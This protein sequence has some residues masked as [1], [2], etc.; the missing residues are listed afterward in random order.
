M[1]TST[2]LVK[3]EQTTPTEA[4][5]EEVDILEEKKRLEAVVTEFEL[6]L[7]QMIFDLSN[8]HPDLVTKVNQQTPP[9]IKQYLTDAE[10]KE[11]WRIIAGR[12]HPDK[13]KNKDEVLHSIFLRAKKHKEEGNLAELYFCYIELLE[14]TDKNSLVLRLLKNSDVIRESLQ[15]LKTRYEQMKVG[16]FGKLY[17]LY[18]INRIGASMQYR[19]YL[20]MKA[21]NQI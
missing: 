21:K 2:E 6:K 11:I 19:N 8:D 16:F 20:I 9:P 12:C 3:V 1:T 4:T 17:E 13:N 5:P 14:Y 18:T 7:N 15:M 10:A